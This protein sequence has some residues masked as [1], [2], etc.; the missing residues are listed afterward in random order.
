MAR[1]AINLI[2]NASSVADGAAVEFEGGRATL[3]AEA[4]TYPT[5][6]QL[7]TMSR[8]GKWVPIGSATTADGAQAIDCPRGQYR[9]HMTGGTASAVY[10][11]LVPVSY[12]G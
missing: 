10:L 5:T 8:S 1:N 3:I 4:T 12:N 6:V 9:V 11:T 7:Q 2:T